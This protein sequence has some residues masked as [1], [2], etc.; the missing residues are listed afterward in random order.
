MATFGKAQMA[1]FVVPMLSIPLFSCGSSP[2]APD[3][4]SRTDLGLGRSSLAISDV[5]Q[6]YAYMDIPQGTECLEWR[7]ADEATV[8]SAPIQPL[9]PCLCFGPPYCWCSWVGQA[10]TYGCEESSGLCC[11]FS[12]TCL[13]CGWAMPPN[14]TWPEFCT[15]CSEFP[16]DPRCEPILSE[17][18]RPAEQFEWL[19][20]T[21]WSNG[22][23]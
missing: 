10:V 9:N 12:S 20:C 23:K 11:W 19:Q 6:A 18:L 21:S 13:P 22:S 15:D 2:T 7:K 14:A 4:F 17:M 5:N 16:N 1:L 3:A 8:K